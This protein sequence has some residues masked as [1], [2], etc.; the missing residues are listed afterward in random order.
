MSGGY[1]EGYS[2]CP[3]FW[4]TEPGSFVK[5]LTLHVPE[6]AGQ[7]ILDA[8]CGE[9]KNAVFL[10]RL[11]AHVEAVDTSARAVAN[12]RSAWDSDA[13]RVSWRVADIRKMMLQPDHYD[14]VI[15]YGLLHCLAQRHEILS[16]ISRLQSATRRGGYHVVCAFNDRHQQLHAHPGFHPCLLTH[17][18]YLAAYSTWQ[19]I[20]ASDSDLTEAHPHNR[21]QHTHSL[22]RI[23]ASKGMQ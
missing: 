18:E 19:V 16:L 11:G 17:Q 12:G 22:S 3:C 13:A 14:I 7:N 9:G 21:I 15:A 6:F 4:G 2:R 20:A 10:A 23:L 5:L 1:D 8:G